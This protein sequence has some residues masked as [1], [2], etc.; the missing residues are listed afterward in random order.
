VFPSWERPTADDRTIV[1]QKGAYALHE[2]R[3]LLGDA[4]FWAGI[5]RYTSDHFGQPVT[6]GDFR[7]AM[8]KASGRDLQAFF[9]RWV[10]Q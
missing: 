1:Y 7:D 2:L 6:T 8:E 10:Y 9:D 4:A 3:E 5:R